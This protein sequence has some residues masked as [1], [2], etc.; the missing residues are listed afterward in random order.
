VLISGLFIEMSRL[1]VGRSFVICTDGTGSFTDP[2]ASVR[3]ASV[4]QYLRKVTSRFSM[5][6]LFSHA[7]Y[8]TP[9]IVLGPYISQKV[10]TIAVMWVAGLYSSQ[11]SLSRLITTLLQSLASPSSS[12]SS[13][14][15]LS[16]KYGGS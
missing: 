16:V 4:R 11:A 1:R 7:S 12:T 15:G 13:G 9:S 2:P 14:S 3:N 8:N 10:C 6:R 5:R